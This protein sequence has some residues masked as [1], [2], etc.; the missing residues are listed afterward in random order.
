MTAPPRATSV[1]PRKR[2]YKVILNGR[3]S[4]GDKTVGLYEHVVTFANHRAA[5]GC[6]LD[7]VVHGPK[8]NR[9]LV[10]L[11]D[12]PFLVVE[13]QGGHVVTVKVNWSGDA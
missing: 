12:K 10:R 11:N 2:P 1:R 9:A 8:D 5:Y 4:D 6:A 13:K 3:T 7:F